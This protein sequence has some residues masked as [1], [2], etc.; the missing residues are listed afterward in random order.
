MSE[1]EKERGERGG[2]E[3]TAAKKEK[4][5]ESGKEVRGMHTLVIYD[6]TEDELR[7]KVAQICK[8]KGL[9]RVQK[10]AFLGEIGSGT[11]KELVAA[12]RKLLKGTEDNAQVYVI[13]DPDFSMRVELGKEYRGEESD[14]L[15]RA[16]VRARG[17]RD[18]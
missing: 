6:V 12:L 8:A 3:K 16:R 11:R 2:I 10:S 1:G 13:C 7:G 5:E 9:V 18:V 17:D 4:E 15:V 14:M